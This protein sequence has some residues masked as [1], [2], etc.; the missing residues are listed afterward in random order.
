VVRLFDYQ[1][2]ADSEVNNNNRIEI[3]AETLVV[4]STQ[5]EQIPSA[6]PER[7]SRVEADRAGWYAQGENTNLES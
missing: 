1:N 7:P 2:R 6:A 4:H 5:I 3:M